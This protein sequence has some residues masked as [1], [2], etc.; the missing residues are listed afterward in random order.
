TFTGPAGGALIALAFIQSSV[1]PNQRQHVPLLPPKVLP[2][3][4][5][6]VIPP[7]LVHAD[8]AIFCRLAVMPMLGLWGCFH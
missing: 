8:F 6:F 7:I 1:L 2:A 3:E 4:A 5:A